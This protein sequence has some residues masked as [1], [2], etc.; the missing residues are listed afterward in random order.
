MV[1]NE[2]FKLCWILCI[3]NCLSSFS[4]RRVPL[5]IVH[6]MTL[7]RFVLSIDGGN[8]DYTTLDM[9]DLCWVFIG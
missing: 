1:W 4:L 7:V 8:I 5:V 3:S 2:I 6:A 9:G